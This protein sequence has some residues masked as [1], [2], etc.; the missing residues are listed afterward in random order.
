MKKIVSKSLL[1]LSVGAMMFTSCNKET[2]SDQSKEIE[3]KVDSQ[4]ELELSEF[5]DDDITNIGNSIDQD[6]FKL[7]KQDNRK[8]KFYGDCAEVTREEKGSVVK[9]TVDFGE[10]C[11]D[12]RGNI[13]SG[14]ISINKTFN[15]A[16]KTTNFV[17]SFKDY[18]F[19]GNAVKGT[20]VLKRTWSDKE[21][22]LATTDKKSTITIILADDA[23]TITR[24][25]NKKR[26]WLEG[27][28]SGNWNDNVIRVTGK[29]WGKNIKGDFYR[30]EIIEPVIIKNSCENRF[31]EGVKHRK[32]TNG[33]EFT[34]DFGNG[35]CDDYFTVTVDEEEKE[36]K[37]SER[38]KKFKHMF[39][40]N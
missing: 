38:K 16:D 29:A 15:K 24:F 3:V 31:V 1:V 13:R 35:E 9:V 7:G 40:Y 12:S 4:I 39:K 27:F 14:K 18:T 19:N 36:V 8:G 30:T 5:V 22:G 37:W 17:Y 34:V 26:E 20:K 2:A 33:K 10:A 23:G 6:L 25:T 32:V 11:E 28:R 21:T